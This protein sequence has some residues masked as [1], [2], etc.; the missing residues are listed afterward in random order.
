VVVFS[1]DGGFNEA[2]NGL[3]SDVPIGFLPGD[4]EDKLAPYLRP[5]Y[6]ALSDR[7]SMKRVRALMAEG[8][9]E[10]AP[11]GFMRGRTLNNAFVVIDEA[12]NC[13][14]VQLKMLLTAMRHIPLTTPVRGSQFERTSGFANR[15]V[16]PYHQKDRRE[17]D[18][19]QRADRHEPFARA[20]GRTTLRPR[21]IDRGPCRHITFLC[22][23]RSRCRAAD[24][25]NAPYHELLERVRDGRD[26][27]QPRRVEEAKEP[28]IQLFIADPARLHAIADIKAIVRDVEHLPAD[29]GDSTA[30]QSTTSALDAVERK[31]ALIARVDHALK[32]AI[33][34]TLPGTD[35]AR[36]PMADLDLLVH[37]GDREP[38][39][40]AL[41]GLGYARE[42]DDAPHRLRPGRKRCRDLL[43]RQR[44]PIHPHFFDFPGNLSFN[45][46]RSTGTSSSDAMAILAPA[47]SRP[48]LPQAAARSGPRRSASAADGGRAAATRPSGACSACCAC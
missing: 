42:H 46:E 24:R 8:A 9:I 33:L 32:G 37:P 15:L 7:L 16:H 47:L 6:D 3:E 23:R 21:G 44:P 31:D 20:C 22:G 27:A 26:L 39:A 17:R 35:P 30:G 40:A 11:V 14:Y 4:A 10:I 43:W 34:T 12:Q 41:T 45:Y 48:H 18:S 28:A 13:T 5:L 36:R 38:L 25:G 1:G 2:L 19:D 29:I